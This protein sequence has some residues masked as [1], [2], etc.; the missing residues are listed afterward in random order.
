MRLPVE[1]FEKERHGLFK[2]APVRL[3]SLQDAAQAL[4]ESNRPS[5]HELLAG[6]DR[7][8]IQPRCG[9]G[10]HQAMVALLKH[11]EE[12]GEPDILT[13]TIDSY[14]RL[15]RYDQA[16]QNL[17]G[18]NGYPLVTHGP[19]RGR[20]LVQSVSCPLQVRHGSP[21]GR[22]LAEVTYASGISAFEGGGISYNLPYAKGISLRTSL[23]HWQYVDRLTGLLSEGSVLDRETFGPLTS[24]L[25]PPSIS[26]AV[27]VLEMLLAVEQG[28]RCVTIGYPE[29]GAL[30]QDVAAVRAIPGLCRRYLQALELPQPEIFISFHQ[31]MGVFPDDQARALALMAA[32]VVTAIMGGAHKLINKTFQESLGIPSAEANATS[33]RF[34]RDVA[35]YGE[36]WARVSLPRESLEE[37]NYWLGRE[38]DEL[39][40]PVLQAG[41]PDLAAAVASAF[42]AGRLDIPFPASRH[43]RGAVIPARDRDGAIRYLEA[44]HLPFSDATLAF[45]RRTLAGR[46]GAGI[47]GILRDLYLLARGRG[48]PTSRRR[49]TAKPAPPADPADV[50]AGGSPEAA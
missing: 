43:A 18:L 4:R 34:C 6:T 13:V 2:A 8:L 1:V 45:H 41:T 12:H 3:V 25:T 36:A 29:T 37:E 44:G 27:S 32:G 47:H 20:E 19:A 14:T 46:H 50:V 49:P 16:A 28:V 40:Q 21:D 10:D 22:L 23:A 42:E 24:V 35:H 38:V 17:A 30:V 26:I 39:L 15:N 48:A 11:L 7:L 9:V 33:I 31:W 5:V